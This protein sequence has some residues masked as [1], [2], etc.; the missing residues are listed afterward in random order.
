MDLARPGEARPLFS[1]RHRGAW[2]ALSLYVRVH[3]VV[4]ILCLIVLAVALAA[5]EDT[6]TPLPA[7]RGSSVAETGIASWYGDP[8]HGRHAAN[9]EIYDM[10]KMTA[11]HKTL[12][13][14][15]WVRVLNLDNRKEVRVRINDRGPFIDGRI[16]DLSRAAARSIGLLIPGITPVA[17]EVLETPHGDGT[18]DRFAVQVG[19]FRERAN[20][21]AYSE[22]MRTGYGEAAVISRD[23]DPL[24][25]VLVGSE[26]TEASARRLASRLRRDLSGVAAFAVRVDPL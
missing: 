12:P 20:A 7:A 21:D 11:A 6:R 1:V 13:F 22:Q 2:I 14:N 23:G 5:A 25:R 3:V 4:P 16:I 17:V 18:P 9:G 15:T 10:E 8:Y 19:A 24:W 26:P